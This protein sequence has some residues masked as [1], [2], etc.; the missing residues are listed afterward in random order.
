MVLIYSA[1]SQCCLSVQVALSMFFQGHSV[2]PPTSAAS[3]QH[4]SNCGSSNSSVN[5]SS[6]AGS[7]LGSRMSYV[8]AQ[9]SKWL[10]QS[11]LD[12]ILYSKPVFPPTPL[13]H[14]LNFPTPWQHLRS[15]KPP[16]LM[17]HPL[18][19]YKNLPLC[20]VKLRPLRAELHLTY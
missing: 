11:S 4:L 16:V 2:P 6:S 20:T 12:C 13:L 9:N 5:P 10:V 3:S 1:N 15:Y 7:S 14:L 8:S 19:C 17:K 18:H